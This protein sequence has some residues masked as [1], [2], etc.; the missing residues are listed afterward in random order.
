MNS[1]RRGGG[2]KCLLAVLCGVS[3]SACSTSPLDFIPK[4]EL[5]VLE[6]QARA[7]RP[8]ENISIQEL[9]AQARGA[10]D[11]ETTGTSS[12]AKS[13][14]EVVADEPAKSSSAVRVPAHRLVFHFKPGKTAPDPQQRSRLEAALRGAKLGRGH[15]V[16]I[17]TGPAGIEGDVLAAVNAQR[18]AVGLA[19]LITRNGARIV[20]R[21][22][23]GLPTGVVILELPETTND[24]GA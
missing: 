18:R 23:P 6:Q 20:I 16:W 1:W 17:V 21:H 24:R 15:T 22:D 14:G 11:G 13:S 7:D 10:A 5:S 9:L 2:P 3:L 12:P 4:H 19:R 8:A